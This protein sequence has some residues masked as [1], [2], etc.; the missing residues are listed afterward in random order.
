MKEEIQSKPLQYSKFIVLKKTD[1]GLP[2]GHWTYIALIDRHKSKQHWWTVDKNEA[3]QFNLLSA[4]KAKAKSLKYGH[5]IVIP[6]KQ[7][8]KYVGREFWEGR[9][10]MALT[11]EIRAKENEWHDDDWYEGI[12][13]D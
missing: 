10:N 12:N 4:A 8:D 11:N 3:M 9:I 7:F 13:D 2:S 5:C 1:Q 6:A